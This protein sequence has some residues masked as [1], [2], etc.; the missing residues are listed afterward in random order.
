MEREGEWLKT[1][2]KEKEDQDREMARR[3][4]M[5]T[6]R[7]VCQRGRREAM[8]EIEKKESKREKAHR[9]EG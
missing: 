2:K 8:V 7:Y 1:C 9:G 5:K 3:V 6:E 4:A